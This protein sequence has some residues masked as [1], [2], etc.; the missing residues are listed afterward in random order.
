MGCEPSTG[1]YLIRK[2]L[3]LALCIGAPLAQAEG[4]QSQAGG[5]YAGMASGQFFPIKKWSSSYWLGG[6]GN[7][8]L[9]Y[10]FNSN[11]SIQLATNMWLLSGDGNDT[12]DLKIL[13]EVK[14]NLIGN[15][16]SPYLLAGV[17]SD[18]QLNYP[19]SISTWNV[20]LPLGFGVEWNGIG[21][22]ASPSTL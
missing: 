5:W 6:G 18:H 8:L 22:W 16:W 13:P 17:G 4:V 14:S 12:W 2:L 20:V 15:K 3:I 10:K 11:L 21:R 19:G 9:G 1:G 7:F